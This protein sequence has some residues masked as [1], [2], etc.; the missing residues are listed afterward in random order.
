MMKKAGV[1]LCSG[2]AAV[3][4]IVTLTGI[5]IYKRRIG[6]DATTYGVQMDV[7]QPQNT[8]LE[9]SVQLKSHL[10]QENTITT[11]QTQHTSQIYK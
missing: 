10:M 1:F 3:D 9:Q 5:N 6:Y 8:C 11:A 7:S 2:R 4:R